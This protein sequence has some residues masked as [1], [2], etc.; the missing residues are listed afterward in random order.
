[1]SSRTGGVTQRDSVSNKHQKRMAIEPG[2]KAYRLR[3]L[4]ALLLYLS[5]VSS[6]HIRW[7][8]LPGTSAPGEPIPLAPDTELYLFVCGVAGHGVHVIA[9][10]TFLRVESGR[11]KLK[12]ARLG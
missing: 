11:I 2:D 4:V 12:T 8:P 5:Q 7:L 3:A 9:W 6:S 10:T 1:M